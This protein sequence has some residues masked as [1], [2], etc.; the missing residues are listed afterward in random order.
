[1]SASAAYTARDVSRTVTDSTKT[2]LAFP[3][4]A[5][6]FSNVGVTALASPAA[7]DIDGGGSSFIAERLAA[8]SVSPGA[9]VTAN[10]F[11]FTWPSSPPGTK[12]NVASAGETIQVSGK[13][14]ALAFLGTGTSGSAGGSATVHYMDGSSAAVTVGFPN[15]C[16][17]ATDTY[18]AKT[19]VTT[20]GKN[21]PSGAAYPTVAYR[22]YTKTVRLDPAKEVAAV[23]LPA[24]SAVHVFAMTVGTEDVVPPPI[25]DGQYSLGNV[26][27]GLALEAPGSDSSQL[28]T[29]AVSSSATQK[30]VVTLQDSGAY[31]VKNAQS[32]QCMDVFS[33]SQT[34]GALVGQY[35]CTGTTNQQWTI[36][37]SGTQLK[38]TA[39]HSG[40][41]LAVDGTGKV[42]QVTDTGAATQRWTA[43]AN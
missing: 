7:G 34:S 12:D 14:N 36:T 29:A 20:M 24:N 22:L 33:S 6:A 25:A 42:V 26:G 43:T 28:G 10:G 21:T 9:K 5:S 17:L 1:V 32:G 16:C 11:D 18:G 30:W 3:S 23:T 13:G 31:Q 37:R 4:L 15:W 38:L 39:K 19:A 40:L 41:S 8:Q 35:T 27:S 2:R